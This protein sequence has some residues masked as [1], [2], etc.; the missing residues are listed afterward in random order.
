MSKAPSR[1]LSDSEQAVVARM[2]TL[3]GVAYAV[4]REVVDRCDCGCASVDFLPDGPFGEIVADA[5]GRTTSGIDVGVI[6]WAREGAVSGLEVYMLGS[7]DTDELP[8]VDS[9]QLEPPF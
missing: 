7:S 2:M 8:T 5:Y 3:G 1:P 4:P 6:L 9:L